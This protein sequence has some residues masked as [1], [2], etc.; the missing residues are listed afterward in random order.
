MTSKKQLANEDYFDRFAEKGYDA[1]MANDGY[2]APDVV[3]QAICAEERSPADI[4]D[5]GIG[6]GALSALLRE[7]FKEAHIAGVDVSKKMLEDAAKRKIADEL[8]QLDITKDQLP[9]AHNR[10]DVSAACAVFEF[11]PDLKHAFNEM[12]R[13][14]K[15]GGLMIVACEAQGSPRPVDD[16]RTEDKAAVTS[17]ESPMPES[18]FSGGKSLSVYFHSVQSVKTAMEE[19]GIE[20]VSQKPFVAY[21][22]EQAK[23]S[24]VY[25]LYIG[26][27]PAV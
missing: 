27:K 20:F 11:L 2:Q 10:F 17:K 25:R 12:A 21:T 19:A 4:L 18:W 26:R 7:E 1:L 14:T 13:V 23:M 6:T 8:V 3:F 9:F 24:Y 22:D 16:L 5:V 15:P